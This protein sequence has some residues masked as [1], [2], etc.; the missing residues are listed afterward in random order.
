MLELAWSLSV[1]E[2]QHVLHADNPRQCDNK[3]RIRPA[4]TPSY[5]YRKVEQKYQQHGCTVIRSC[6]VF[7]VKGFLTDGKHC[8][9][10]AAVLIAF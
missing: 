2:V 9:R 4:A 10:M 7:L 1:E 8:G 5:I 6:G 3:S